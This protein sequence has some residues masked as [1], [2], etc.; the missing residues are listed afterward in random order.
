[1]SNLKQKKYTSKKQGKTYLFQFPGIRAVTKIKDRV[2]N[3][4]GIP[5]DERT[6]DE[7]LEHVIV[8]PK[9]KIED[10]DDIGEF[11]EVIGAAI[12]FMHGIDDEED[13]ANQS[14]RS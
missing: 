13:D 8:D 3:K 7:M 9:M 5:L 10:F 4:Y 12:N 2:K 11:N 6:A 1:M 14:E